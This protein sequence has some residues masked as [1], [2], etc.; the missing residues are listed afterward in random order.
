MERQAEADL[1]VGFKLELELGYSIKTVSNSSPAS[2]RYEGLWVAKGCLLLLSSVFRAYS[3]RD[4][5]ADRI[6]TG[7]FCIVVILYNMDMRDSD[8]RDAKSLARFPGMFRIFGAARLH[9]QDSKGIQL[10]SI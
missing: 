3:G 7:V 6:Q 9:S 5:E 8:R 1:A 10:S 2:C 4:L